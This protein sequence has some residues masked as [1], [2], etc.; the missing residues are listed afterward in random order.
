MLPPTV[1]SRTYFS[2][3]TPVLFFIQR[4][5]DSGLIKGPRQTMDVTRLNCALNDRNRGAQSVLARAFTTVEGHLFRP[6]PQAQSTCLTLNTTH[7][8]FW[9]GYPKQSCPLSV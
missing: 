7:S 9:A 5:T 4:N 8:N 3:P 6:Q 1:A 2:Q